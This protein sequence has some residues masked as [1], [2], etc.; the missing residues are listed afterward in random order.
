MERLRILLHFSPVVAALLRTH[1]ALINRFSVLV[2]LCIYVLQLTDQDH[3]GFFAGQTPPRRAITLG[4]EKG[5]HCEEFNL[6]NVRQHYAK[7]MHW[8]GS[9]RGYYEAYRSSSEIRPRRAGNLEWRFSC[10]GIPAAY[11]SPLSTTLKSKASHNTEQC[12][13]TE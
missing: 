11:L 5:G 10:L 8:E 2:T 3:A 6:C 12:R 13:I 9:R 1:R 4:E 7:S